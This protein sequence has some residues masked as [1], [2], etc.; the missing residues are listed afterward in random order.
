ML[1][2]QVVEEGQAATAP[3]DPTRDGYTFIGWDKDFSAVTTDLTVTAQYEE[4]PSTDPTIS[5]GNVVGKAGDTVTVIV[6]I[7]NSPSLVTAGVSITYDDSV[8]TLTRATSGS[9]MS[10]LMFTAPANMKSGC[11]AAWFSTGAAV[12]PVDGEMLVLTFTI[13]DTAPAG[14]YTIQVAPSAGDM[15]DEM[16]GEVSFKALSGT[17]TIR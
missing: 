17:V 3:T 7:K 6:S 15:L 5:V 10:G 14:N 9:S 1:K 4:I 16:Y 2:T 11:K 13:L 12:T 8:M